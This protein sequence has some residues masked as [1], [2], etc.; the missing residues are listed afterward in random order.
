M[1]KKL[2]KLIV[3]RQSLTELMNVLSETRLVDTVVDE[4]GDISFDIKKDSKIDIKTIDI[5]EILTNKIGDLEEEQQEMNTNT[6]KYK[7]LEIK[8]SS[9]LY[10]MSVIYDILK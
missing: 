9:I 3:D 5:L 7:E 6:K 8:K 4:K 1:R 2:Y 10:A